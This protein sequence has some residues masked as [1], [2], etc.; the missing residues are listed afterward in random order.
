[1]RL[2]KKISLFLASS[3]LLNMLAIFYFSP[4]DELKIYFFDVGQ[5]DAILISDSYGRQ[6]IID[7]GPNDK[8]SYYLSKLIPAGDKKIEAILV[9]HS[10][11]D[12]YKGLLKVL[13]DYEVEQIIM[14]KQGSSAKTWGKFVELINEKNIP[15]YS[16]VGESRIYVG[17]NYLEIIWPGIVAKDPNNS[18]VVSQ[19]NVGDYNIMLMGDA[20]AVVE[21]AL[22]RN[23]KLEQVEVLK[24]GHHGSK[25]ATSETFLAKIK[26]RNAII[27][28][29]KNNR[30][31]HPHKELL[32]RLE[33]KA[34]QILRTDVDGNIVIT[35]VQFH[36]VVKSLKYM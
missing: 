8:L 5:G 24:V 31:G 10:H 14:P 21:S 17:E 33:S 11:Y 26:G 23:N 20:G 35:C 22:A 1:M 15:A 36:C 28:V 6:I 27:S 2:S 19:F 18:S 4:K 13:N 3:V 34:Y 7:G 32:K 30:Y 29:G 9:T 12:H 16:P 25:Y